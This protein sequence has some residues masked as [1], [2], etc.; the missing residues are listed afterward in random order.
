ML[1]SCLLLGSRGGEDWLAKETFGDNVYDLPGLDPEAASILTERILERYG[2]TKYLHE[3]DLHYLLKLLDGFPLA[4][5]VVL[6]NLARQTP[7]EVLKALQLG[8]VTISSGSSE[9]RTENILRCIDYSH[10]NLSPES[11]QLLLCMSPFTSVIWIDMLDQ[12]ITHLKQQP[13]IANLHY[14]RWPEVIR[15]TQNWGLLSPNPDIPGFLHLQPTLSYFLRN[16]LNSTEQVEVRGAIET[17]FREHYIELGY[18]LR[19]CLNPKNPV[20]DR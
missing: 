1:R 17:A 9:K 20:S 16:R 18:L 3:T 19:N 13:A 4:L 10:S 15:E 6:A 14:D 8:E 5:E 2:V 11:Q 7:T 12:Y